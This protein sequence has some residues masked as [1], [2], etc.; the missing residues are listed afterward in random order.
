MIYRQLCGEK[1]S[2]LGFGAMRLPVI[3]GDDAKIDESKAEE[4]V[5]YAY[6]HGINYFDSAWTYHGGNSEPF[7]AKVLSK[8]PRESYF[9]T[10]KFPGFIPELAG[11]VEEVFEEQIKK[12]GLE[13]FDFY[14]VHNVVEVDIDT[15]LNPKSGIVP[16]LIEQKKKGRIRHLGFSAHGSA[17][18]IQRFLETYGDEMEFCQLQVNWVDWKYQHADKKVELLRKYKLPLW[19]M[20]PLRGGRLANLKEEEIAPLKALRPNESAAGWAFRFLQSIDIAGVTLTGSSSLE[21]LAENITVWEEDKPLSDEEMK[22]L[23]SLAESLSKGV[24]CT[25]CK[26]CVSQCPKVLDI[27]RLIALYNDDKIS[28]GWRI[29]GL[30]LKFLPEYTQPSCCIHCGKCTEVCP[31]GIK[32]PDILAELVEWK[33]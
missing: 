15:Y 28:N 11:K 6:E 18:T 3:D 31:Q 4:M 5:D 1:I 33:G 29:T 30:F 16:Y 19:I 22:V 12:T 27:P 26:Y 9:I 7:M 13:Y 10:S 8:Y 23:L 32:I 24:P 25:G 20:E 2:A 17:E 14:L 21:Q